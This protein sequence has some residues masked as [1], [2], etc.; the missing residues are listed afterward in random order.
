MAEFEPMRVTMKV[1][2]S[3]ETHSMTA[4]EQTEQYSMKLTSSIEPKLSDDYADLTNKPIINDVTLEGDL[5]S[6]DLGL[7]DELVFD[8]YPEDGS[9]NPVTSGGIALALDTKVDKTTLAPGPV[10]ATINNTDGIVTIDSAK[11]TGSLSNR[12]TRASS[13]SF[14]GD[15]ISISQSKTSNGT[16]I[17]SSEVSVSTAGITANKTIRLLNPDSGL[18]LTLDPGS[19]NN[20]GLI[21]GLRDPAN[22]N[23]AANKAYVDS[24]LSNKADASVV[25][26]ELDAKQ[27]T[28]Y[29]TDDSAHQYIVTSMEEAT[30]GGVHGFMLY[31]ENASWFFPDGVGLNTVLTSVNTAIAGKQP[32]GD[33]ATNSALTSGLATKQPVGD[34]AT[35][36]DLNSGLAAKQNVL[37]FDSAPTSGSTNPVESGGVYM[38]LAGKQNTIPDL[39]DIRSGAEL[40]ETAVQREEDPTVPAWAKAPAKPSYTASEVGAL[41]DST[42]IPSKTS[43]LTNDSGFI[44]QASIPVQSVN[45]QTGSVVLTIP[46]VPTNVSAFTNDSGYLTLSTLPIYNGGVS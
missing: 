20:Y 40:G 45:G 7:Q 1:T 15:T 27:D 18:A 41:P 4:H 11:N 12:Q 19:G 34:Y 25:A 32:I 2:E 23:D 37:T 43:D 22:S 5:T 42:E 31:A 13:V 33:Y 38:A 17:D 14:D 24:G 35:N 8:S 10:T 9:E 3:D 28:I 30:V 44:T 16:V 36:S 21:S 39:A 46:T 26:D 6:A 29:L